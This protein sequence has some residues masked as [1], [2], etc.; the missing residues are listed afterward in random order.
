MDL[1]ATDD[2]FISLDEKQ[3]TAPRQADGSLPNITFMHL[4]PA[5]KFVDKGMD[6]G[7]PYKGAAPDLGCFELETGKK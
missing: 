1:N 4:K 3:L 5:S 6:I 7:Y 2:D